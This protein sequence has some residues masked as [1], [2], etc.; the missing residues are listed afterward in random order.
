MKDL[1]LG[2]RGYVCSLT[3]AKSNK[4]EHVLKTKVELHEIIYVF[5]NPVM[6][7]PQMRANQACLVTCQKFCIFSHS[8]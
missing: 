2:S 6:T 8:I 1:N 3:M 5:E 7:P 4:V